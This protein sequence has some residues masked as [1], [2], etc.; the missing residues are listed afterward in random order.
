MPECRL[1]CAS[2]PA[3]GP[4]PAE[5]PTPAGLAGVL[6]PSGPE[7]PDDRKRR[8]T[9]KGDRTSRAAGNRRRE[10][11]IFFMSKW[12]KTAGLLF[13]AASAVFANQAALGQAAPAPA[14]N[15]PFASGPTTAP[16]S[17]PSEGPPGRASATPEVNV[18]DAGTVEIH[19]ND[20]NLVE[21]LRML[22]LQSQKN[23]IAQQ[24][25]PRHRHRQPL[26]RDRPRG[27]RRDPPRQRLRLPREGQLHLRLHD[28]GNRRDRE[29]RAAA[30]K[31]EVFRL[32]YTP[33]ANAANMIKPVLSTEAQ[34]VVHDAGQSPASP[35][36]ASDAGGNCA[37]RP[38]TCSSSP[39]T[40]RTS[41][42][43][44]KILKEIDRRPQQI[45]RRGRRSS[46]PR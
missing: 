3:I 5:Q 7:A 40:P 19:V 44:R 32:Y 16:T 15:D 1:T 9:E 33:A 12:T 27:A 29:G 28:Q 26:R 17:Q 4:W 31:T 22:S 45:L 25:R 6:G 14:A 24:G 46:A 10:G 34:V 13:A 21:V 8:S 11:R 37:R 41:T 35:A 39:T 20:A 18:T 36:T 42:Q 43:V 38:R 23:I 2:R 30:C